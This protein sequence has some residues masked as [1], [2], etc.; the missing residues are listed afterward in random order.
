MGFAA[1]A[2]DQI[3][4]SAVTLDVQHIP[5]DAA[6]GDLLSE[7]RAVAQSLRSRQQALQAGGWRPKRR[8][9]ECHVPLPCCQ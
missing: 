3:A 9:C 2:G 5:L 1:S 6:G 4:K 7:A 8:S